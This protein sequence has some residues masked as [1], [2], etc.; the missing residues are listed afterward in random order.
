MI[1]KILFRITK[2]K[3]NYKYI[4]IYKLLIIFRMNILIKSKMINSNH[5]NS[6]YYKITKIKRLIRNNYLMNYKK[7]MKQILNE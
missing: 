5:I 2:K 1:L 3:L 4:K 7:I 6:N